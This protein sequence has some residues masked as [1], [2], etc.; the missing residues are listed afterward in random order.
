[1]DKWLKNKA[2]AVFIEI[3]NNTK[4]GAEALEEFAK[5]TGR[6]SGED[7]LYF[8]FKKV[9]E[10]VEFCKENP[11]IAEEVNELRYHL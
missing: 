2:L 8:V 9:A 7:V 1:M 4:H 10:H 3:T 11:N 5:Y 6:E